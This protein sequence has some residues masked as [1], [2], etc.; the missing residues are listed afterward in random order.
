MTEPEDENSMEWKVR[1]FQHPSY[2]VILNM[3]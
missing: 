2:P 3:G 1:R